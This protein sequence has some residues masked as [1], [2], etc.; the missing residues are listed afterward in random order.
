MHALGRSTAHL[1]ALLLLTVAACGSR[2][3]PPPPNPFVGDAGLWQRM[4]AAEDTR[5]HGPEGLAPLFEG[6]HA[7]NAAVRAMA[8]RALGRLEQDSLVAVIAPVLAD[9]AGPVRAEAANALSQAVLHS[10]GGSVRSLLL[11]RLP[12]ERDPAVQGV[13]TESLG[14]LQQEDAGAAASTADAILEAVSGRS[15]ASNRLVAGDATPASLVESGMPPPAP[16][17]DAQLLGAVRGFYFLVRQPVG[18]NTLSAAA[19]AF[20]VGAT[21]YG[22]ESRRPGA[23]VRAGE[24]EDQPQDSAARARLLRRRIRTV[25]TAA[26]VATGTAPEPELMR[27]M[28]DA[29]PLV[30]REAALGAA[31][32]PAAARRRLVRLAMADLSPL[33]RYE[34]VRAWGRLLQE[35]EGCEPLRAA[36]RDSAR[37]VALAAIDLLGRCPSTLPL[38]DSL[39]GSFQ[40]GVDT[41]STHWHRAAHALVALARLDRTE[42]KARLPAFLGSGDLFVRMYAARAAAALADTA[43]LLH[44]A[45][46]SQPDVRTAAIAGLAAVAGHAADS[47]YVAQLTATDAQ[48]LRETATALQGTTDAAAAPALLAALDRVSAQRRETS[49]DG[50]LA[51]LDRLRELGNA[52]TAERLQPY[53]TDFDPAIA[54][55][56]AD[57]LRVWTGTR[58]QPRP[59]PLTTATL[60]SLA[61][62]DSL[63]AA[64]VTIEMAAGG[65]IRLHLFPF[66]A[67]TNAAR[68]ARL[69][70]QGYYDGLTFHRVVPN[71]V[72]QGGSPAANEYAGAGPFTRDELGLRDNWRGTVGLSTRGRDTGDA[73]FY[74]NLVDN[75]RLDHEYTVFGEVVS[76]MTVV[77]HLAEGAV[78]RRVTVH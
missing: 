69:A 29:D 23:L 39:A 57:V 51:L 34:G 64:T 19:R 75:V 50:R 55:G 4:L 54:A 2:T 76:G 37:Q 35:R 40:S 45:A 73:Q 72:I 74:I 7:T 56:A 59:T 44:L 42:G 25:A 5:G 17:R 67:P 60:P 1:P 9:S 33:V 3:P 20:L 65:V 6:L 22:R 31:Y 24:G 61:T 36:A 62:I 77:D 43:A 32:L 11:S 12:L 10:A 47:V 16:G 48:L 41:T 38:L 52:A 46:D 68:F 58:P 21:R 63:A 30:R 53:L 49:R 28:T 66:E 70:R 13:L 15:A 14:R 27:I 78:M 18:R 71:F 8:V 26:L